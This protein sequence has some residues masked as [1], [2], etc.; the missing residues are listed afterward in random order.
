MSVFR[1]W[2]EQMAPSRRMH[3]WRHATETPGQSNR[4]GKGN[5]EALDEGRPV[6][7]HYT[8]E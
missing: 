6:L 1:R 4:F 3:Y 7:L 8:V 5:K 2:R